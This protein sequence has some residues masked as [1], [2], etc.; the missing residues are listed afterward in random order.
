M[1]VRGTDVGVPRSIGSSQVGED[2]CKIFF[3]FLTPADNETSPTPSATPDRATPTEDRSRTSQNPA[4][5]T[6][7]D[8]NSQPAALTSIKDGMGRK[9]IIERVKK[10]TFYPLKRRVV[11][12]RPFD[13][14]ALW[15]QFTLVAQFHQTSVIETTKTPANEVDICQ[16]RFASTEAV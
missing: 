14:T 11:I 2:S 1:P 16:M 12:R 7:E 15:Q 3:F 10:S 6:V 5:N 8:S 13:Q 9:L 4:R